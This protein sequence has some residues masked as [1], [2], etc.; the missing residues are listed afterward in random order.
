[1]R[2]VAERA[3][4]VGGPGRVGQ[5]GYSVAEGFAKAGAKLV[6]SDVG[7]TIYD[8]EAAKRAGIETVGV[9][10]GGFSEA[11]LRAAGAREVFQSVA[12][13]RGSNVR[14]QSEIDELRARSPDGHA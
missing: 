2:D 5:I 7:D 1:M 6:I 14:L 4:G 13:L 9:L 11:E 10:S 8:C 3:H 12:E